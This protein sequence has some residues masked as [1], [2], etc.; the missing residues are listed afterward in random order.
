MHVC[1][2]KLMSAWMYVFMYASSSGPIFKIKFAA[3]SFK[4]SSTKSSGHVPANT[5][6]GLFHVVDPPPIRYRFIVI[7][8]DSAAFGICEKFVSWFFVISYDSGI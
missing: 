4:K 1:M 6:G 7:C 5:I 8:S 3:T 2:H